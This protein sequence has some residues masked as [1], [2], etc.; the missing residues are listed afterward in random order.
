MDVSVEISK[1]TPTSFLQ[2]LVPNANLTNK[3][4]SVARLHT[5][6][7]IGGGNTLIA[8]GLIDNSIVVG[9]AANLRIMGGGVFGN[10]DTK[11]NGASSK[12]FILVCDPA[13]P[14]SSCTGSGAPILP[15]TV[16]I[17]GADGCKGQI[18]PAPI[19]G[20]TPLDP[21]QFEIPAP[22][23][24]N[25]TYSGNSLPI[26]HGTL[27]PGLY[28]VT[29]EISFPDITAT[30]VTFYLMNQAGIKINGNTTVNLESP[31]VG[32]NP[33]QNGA[34]A[35]LLFFAPLSNKGQLQKDGTASGYFHGSWVLPGMNTTTPGWKGTFQG[36]FRG[37]MIVNNFN[38]EGTFD[39]GIWYDTPWIYTLPA[40]IDLLH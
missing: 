31:Q 35:G 4:T 5:A 15:G 38:M 6:H 3:M 30:G 29:S 2:V 24:T 17:V 36:E 21:A 28:C 25:R 19:E 37:Q 26:N 18:H 1:T 7:A 32:G 39:G 16:N 27:Q 14:V 8:L 13:F 23:C 40:S 20:A 22:D 33:P 11:C 10:A 9:G 34:I 12:E